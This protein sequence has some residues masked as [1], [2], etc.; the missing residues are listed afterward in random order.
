MWKLIIANNNKKTDYE[1]NNSSQKLYIV[2]FICFMLTTNSI[3]Q[4]IFF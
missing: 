3:S 1:N 4:M 2:N